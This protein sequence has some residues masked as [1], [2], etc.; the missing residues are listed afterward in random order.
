MREYKFLFDNDSQAAAKFFPD[1]RVI[2]LTQAKLSTAAP[3]AEIVARA[4]ELGSIIVTA[5]GD[6][7]ERE[8]KRFLQK[9]QRNDCYDLFGLVVIPNPAAIQERVLPGL[10]A[11]LRFNGKAISW[12]EVWRENY[13]VRVHSDGTVE[14]REL[15]RCFYCKKL[16]SE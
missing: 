7:Y 2:T 8:I 10:S 6:D 14:V 15:G 4:R 11:K 5:N 16:Q 1:K 12:D 13:L 3:D 9:S